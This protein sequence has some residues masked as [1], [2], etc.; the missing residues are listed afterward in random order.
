LLRGG[1]LLRVGCT[2]PRGIFVTY[3]SPADEYLLGD[4][5]VRAAL[6]PFKR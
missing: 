3:D 2:L 1:L 5:Q 6:F 4:A